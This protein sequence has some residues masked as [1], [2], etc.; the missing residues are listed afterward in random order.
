MQ[1]DVVVSDSVVTAPTVY[2][3]SSLLLAVY[4][5]SIV[6]GTY[7]KAGIFYTTE[8]MFFQKLLS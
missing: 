5:V 8:G 4:I 1:H 6:L 7:I 2:E 3:Y